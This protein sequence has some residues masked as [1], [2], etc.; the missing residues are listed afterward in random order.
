M[1]LTFCI[2]KIKIKVNKLYKWYQFLHIQLTVYHLTNQS[3]GIREQKLEICHVNKVCLKGCV[4][5]TME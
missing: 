4:I 3:D 2:I 5:K 1:N